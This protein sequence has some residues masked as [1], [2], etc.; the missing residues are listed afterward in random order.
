MNP[1]ILHDNVSG[2]GVPLPGPEPDDPLRQDPDTLVDPPDEGG[3]LPDER[4]P[5][6]RR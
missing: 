5:P 2:D 6:R 1:L 3:S 4:D